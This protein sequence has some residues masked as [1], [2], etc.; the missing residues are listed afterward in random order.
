[1]LCEDGLGTAVFC[2]IKVYNIVIVMVPTSGFLSL[3][4]LLFWFGQV[5]RV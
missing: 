5:P 1:M 2:E 4:R 3:F